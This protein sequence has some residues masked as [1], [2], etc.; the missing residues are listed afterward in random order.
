MNA[1][2]RAPKRTEQKKQKTKDTKVFQ[3]KLNPL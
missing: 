1:R 3:K 2:M